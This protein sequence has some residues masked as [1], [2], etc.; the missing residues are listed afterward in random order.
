MI[1][2]NGL[3]K[4]STQLSDSFSR[5]DENCT[6]EPA[7]RR[8]LVREIEEQKITLAQAIERFNFHP[9]NGYDLIRHWREKYSPSLVL[10]LPNMTAAEKHQ[11]ATLQQQLAASEK[12]LEDAKMKN[13]AL[14]MLIDVA[15]EKLKISIRKKPGAKQ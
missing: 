12:Q 3:R 1:E 5:L 15:E 2:A 13:I 7:F 8:W 9:K 11:L 4:H 10:S 14:N 6:Y